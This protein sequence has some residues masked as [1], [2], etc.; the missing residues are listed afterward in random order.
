M[1]HVD[2]GDSDG[3]DEREER[4]DVDEEITVELHW[5]EH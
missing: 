3:N 5:V 1:R 2:V 4:N